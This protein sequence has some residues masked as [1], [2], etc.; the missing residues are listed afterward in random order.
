M[1]YIDILVHSLLAGSTAGTAWPD[2]AASASETHR[3]ASIVAVQLAERSVAVFTQ[4]DPVYGP[5]QNHDTKL[6][7]C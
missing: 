6:V 1:Q 2:T 3:A 7:D 4:V 5:L